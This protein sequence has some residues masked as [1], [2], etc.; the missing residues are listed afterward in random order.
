MAD[1]KSSGNKTVA[2]AI[3]TLS[4]VGLLGLFSFSYFTAPNLVSSV[5]TATSSLTATQTPSVVIE[6]EEEVPIIPSELPIHIPAPEFV[7]TIYM[8]QCVVG[9][10]SFRADLVE[11]AETTEINSIIIDIKDYTGKLAFE[12]DNPKLVD[13]VSDECGARDMR[14][15]IRM[16]NEKD[17]YVIGRITVFQDPYY[18][19]T[20]PHLAIKKASATST[21]WADY[22]GLS[23]I[24]PGAKEFHD[25]ILEIS[26]ES[27]KIGFDELNFDY[28]RFPSD[29]NMQDIYFPFSEAEVRANP[30]TGRAEVVEA[31]FEYL[32]SELEA[33]T[34]PAVVNGEVKE[35]SPITS[36]D[37]F[38][39]TTTN[40][41]DLTIGQQLEKAL[42]YFDYIAPMVYPS[43]YPN[44]FNGWSNPNDHVYGVIKFSMDRAVERTISSTTPVAA[45]VNERIGTSTPAMYKKPVYDKL[46][47]RP[48]LQDFDYGGDYDIEEVRAQIQATYDAGLNSWMLWAPSNRYTIGALEPNVASSGPATSN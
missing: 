39:M 45:N 2:L 6:E 35:V 16:L 28:I 4:L 46:K 25:Y 8:S 19:K 40:Y 34:I 32:H 1:K 26:K 9:T 11:V 5:Y 41:D 12:T 33:F 18:T 14:S 24:D 31:F 43:H 44:G 20:F 38:G 37:I 3:G 10:P 17:I 21:N 29:G 7:R 13:S 23:F 47:L 27:F 36:A 42:P 30:A 15:F 22:K 48:W